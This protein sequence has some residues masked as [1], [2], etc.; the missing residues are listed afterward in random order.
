MKETSRLA[1][2]VSYNW[3]MVDFILLLSCLRD[4]YIIFHGIDKLKNLYEEHNIGNYEEKYMNYDRYVERV[5]HELRGDTLEEPVTKL[6]KLLSEIF[7]LAPLI[8]KHVEFKLLSNNIIHEI[9]NNEYHISEADEISISKI[10]ISS[11]GEIH[12]EAGSAIKELRELIKD[13]SFRNEQERAFNE[14]KIIQEIITTLDMMKIPPEDIRKVVFRL[15]E[16]GTTI[17]GMINGG[18]LGL[19]FDEKV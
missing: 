8:S 5:A 7:G 13:L 14:L 12:L 15:R 17:E 9:I 18:I 3:K 16:K 19:L 4:L 10:H 1:L 2:R 6:A 11:P